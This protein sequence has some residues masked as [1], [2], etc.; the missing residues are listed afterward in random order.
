MLNI[1]LALHN[2]LRWVV[3]GTAVW[4]LIR[5]YR[6]WAANSEW[7][8]AD[9][10]AGRFLTISFDIQLLVG[11]LLG[12]LS[13]LIRAAVQDP[14]AIGGSEVIRYFA[15]EHIPPMVVAVVLVHVTS[16]LS[17]RGR[18]GPQ[19][20]RRAALG[21]SLAMLLVLVAIPWWRPLLPGF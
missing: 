4:A 5:A 16:V 12:A 20:H 2:V 15:S 18:T 10:T 7:L 3:M 21:Y 17:R 8:P 19:R 9:T 6:G 13:P 11:L 14:S 1:V